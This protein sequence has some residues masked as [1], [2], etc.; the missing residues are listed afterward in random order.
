MTHYCASLWGMSS[1]TGQED[2][3]SSLSQHSSFQGKLKVKKTSEQTSNIVSVPTSKHTLVRVTIA[4][5]KHHVPK[6]F[7]KERKV[8]LTYT[9]S[10][11]IAHHQR[12][13]GQKIR[14]ET[15]SQEL[16]QG[17]MQEHCLL[18]CPFPSLVCLACFLV[19]PRMTSRGVTP[20]TMT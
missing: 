10:S 5:M 2:K 11:I 7:G 15:W 20:P 12:K 14:L 16:M 9:S 19:E 6:K 1:A 17:T 8:Y 3:S 4:I 18:A 13:S